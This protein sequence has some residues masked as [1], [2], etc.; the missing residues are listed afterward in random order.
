M[1]IVHATTI[2]YTCLCR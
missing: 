1:T 2:A